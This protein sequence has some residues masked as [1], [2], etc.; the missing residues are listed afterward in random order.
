MRA[1]LAALL[2]AAS[3]LSPLTLLAGEAP[4]PAT[5]VHW[6]SPCLDML[7]QPQQVQHAWATPEVRKTAQGEMYVLTAKLDGLNFQ[8]CWPDAQARDAKLHEI[9][10][11]VTGGQGHE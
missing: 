1:G 11:A 2:I 7:F 4:K 3:M 9:H 6:K 10:Q 5:W 8:F